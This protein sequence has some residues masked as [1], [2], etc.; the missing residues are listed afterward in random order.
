MSREPTEGG[1]TMAYHA[2]MKKQMAPRNISPEVM[3]QYKAQVFNAVMMGGFSKNT[4]LA[5]WSGYSNDKKR[6]L[7]SDIN[8]LDD[9]RFILNRED[10]NEIL[11]ITLAKKREIEVLEAAAN[12]PLK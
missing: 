4:E 3:G 11:A 5:A 7:I 12:T 10:D 1:G 6:L 9:I 2:E 8:D